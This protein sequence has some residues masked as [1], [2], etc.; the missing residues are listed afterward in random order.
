MTIAVLGLGIIGEAW[1]RNLQ[2]DGLEVRNWNRTAKPDFPGFVSS[3][4]E[5]V[6]GADVIIVV[7]SDPKAVGS[8]LEQAAPHFKRGQ[9]VVQSSTIGPDDSHR[10]ARMVEATGAS[11][12]EAPFTGSKP[13][14]EAR[15]TVFYLGGEETLVEAAR[16]TLQRLSKAI[17]HIGPLGSASALK[18][19]MNLN[20]AGVAFALCE[21]L[22]LARA[23][24]I[25][26][27][28]YF[29]A[30]ENNVARSGLSDLKQPKL[31]ERDY[32]P[33]FSL[34]HMNKDLGLAL[35]AARDSGL[36]ISHTAHLREIYERGIENGL[37][38]DDF[39]VL[40]QLLE[41]EH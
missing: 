29:S 7:V 30:L 17:Y 18:L 34:K 14:A 11:F 25:T 12:L 15:Q 2:S 38:N 24:G 3:I 10:F 41:G 21:S 36:T 33:Q 4:S 40:M 6:E 8:V 19:A 9:I 1:A 31:R 22:A 37:G 26:D 13:A 16:P 27:E 20:I 35:D 23:A 5:A 32:T 39:I 28:V